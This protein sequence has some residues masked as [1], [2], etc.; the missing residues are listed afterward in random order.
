MM[1]KGCPYISDEV[2]A[3]ASV[4]SNA[5]IGDPP[6]PS[7]LPFLGSLLDVKRDRLG[8]LARLT[9]EFGDFVQFRMGKNALYL[10]NDPD[11]I[12]HVLQDNHQNYRK[13]V[14][15]TQAKRWLGEGLVTSEGE[16]WSRQHHLI[17]PAFQRHRLT[18]FGP[19]VTNATS[20]MLKLWSGYAARGQR[21]NV[22]SQMMQLTLGI[23]TRILFGTDINNAGDVGV[24]FSAAL[25]D[26]MN[27]MTAIMILPDWLPIPGKLRFKRALQTL[28][29]IV[30]E[31]IRKHR[32]GEGRPKSLL[33]DLLAEKLEAHSGFGDREL[34]DQVMTL[35]LAGHETTSN[36][37]AWTFYLM[38]HNPQ[39]WRRVRNEVDQVLGGRMPTHDDLAQLIWTRMVLEESLRLYPPVWLIPRQA[40]ADDEISGYLVASGSHVLISPYILHRHLLHWTEPEMFNPERF[41]PTK[42]AKRHQYTYLPFG[43]G[44]R[45]CIGS[46]LAMMEA[47]LIL[48]MVA[49]KYRLQLAT[50]SRVVPEPLLTL[51]FRK[52]LM[53]IPISV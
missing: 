33:S 40:V 10:V 45:A 6:G 16:V 14:G 18:E 21:I 48:A 32:A 20:T 1:A 42:P 52:G 19:V 28:N 37:L 31:I 23:I 25:Q 43:A 46:S 30:D 9:S 17:Q 26:A 51:R 49:Q 2:L 27:R 47:L 8:F 41:S 53:M 38:S 34:R 24:A 4:K 3:A 12:R 39:A 35:L 29:N 7:G 15:L 50:G 13:G 36:S 22:G 44:P 11:G 5:R